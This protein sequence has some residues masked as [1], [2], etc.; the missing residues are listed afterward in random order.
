LLK[1]GQYLKGI[2]IMTH[3]CIKYSRN[4]NQDECYSCPMW[5]ECIYHAPPSFGRNRSGSKAKP[6]SLFLITTIVFSVLF[7]I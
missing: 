7:I 4:V 2:R 5:D 6:I 1:E 3:A